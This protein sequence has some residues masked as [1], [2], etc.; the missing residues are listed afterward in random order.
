MAK[1]K[2]DKELDQYR[3]LLETP[4]TF[5]DG[6][7]WTTIAGIL[8]CGLIM[9]PGAIYLG[10]MTGGNIASAATWVTV[11]LFSEITRRALKTMTKG[12]LIILLHAA[13]IIMGYA[14]MGP[15]GTLVNRAYLVT[16]DAARDMG[17]RDFFPTWWCPKPDS[18]AITERSI[19]HPDWIKPILI[20]LV[21]TFVGLLNKYT[22]GYFFFRLCSDVERLPFPMAPISA[23]GSL[24]LADSTKKPEELEK[25]EN[26]VDEEGHSGASSSSAPSSAW[27]SASSRSA[28]RPSP[29]S[30]STSPSSSSPSPTSTRRR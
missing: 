27:P 7:G 30:S 25:E 11:I 3:N 12:N 20:M 24:A 4:K 1:P 29:A 19:F 9:T 16:S 10:L 14:A 2:V 5:E 26:T 17:M 8:F 13:A 22:V 28:S 6:F 18:A 21:T 15:A 23:Q